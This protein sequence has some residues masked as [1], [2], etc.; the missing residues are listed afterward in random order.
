M[1]TIKTTPV[2]KQ[3]PNIT[4]EQQQKLKELF[5]QAF[6]EGKVDFD[7]LREALGDIVDDKPERYLFSWAGRRDSIRAYQSPSVATLAP[8]REESIDFDDTQNVFI[9]GENLEVLK[10]LLRPYFGQVKMIYIDPPY[11]EDG[12]YVY[13]DNY[14]D[15]LGEYERITGQRDSEGNLL[16]SSRDTSGRYH[17]NW[18][19]MIYPR[20]AL[21]RQLLKE[22]GAIFVSINDIEALSLRLVMNQL[23][24]EENFV[25]QMVWSGGRKNDSKLISVSHEY[26]LCYVKNKE[27]FKE[28]NI[29]WRQ[30]KPG[31]ED[32]YKTY[33]KF[34]KKHPGDHAK[35]EEGLKNWFRGLRNYHPAKRH[36]HYSSVDERG[37]YFP[38]DI[39]WPGGGGPQYEV[40]HPVTGKPCTVPA[41]GWMFSDPAKMQKA[42]SENKVHFGIDEQ[43]V[44]CIKA[45]LEERED[46][47]PYSVFYQDGRASTKRLRRLMGGD[48][49]E[50]PK[51]ELILKNLVEFASSAGDLIVDF[52]A[53]SCT[54]AHSVFLQ[55]QEDGEPRRFIMVQLPEPTKEDSNAFKAGYKNIAEIGKERIRR[56]GKK[57]KDGAAEGEDLGFRVFRLARSNYKQWDGAAEQDPEA[58][59]AQMG[60]FNDPLIEGWKVEDVI[61]E[62]ALKEGFKLTCKVEKLDSEENTI[63]RVSEG[64]DS[65]FI[66]LDD[67]VGSGLVEQLGL[68]KD[69]VF[70]CRDVALSDEQAANLALQCKLKTI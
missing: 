56:A 39:S 65:F 37:I 64:E 70:V 16:T 68:N 36:K 32:I 4:E 6:T 5:P 35:I 7:K 66:C 33:R 12:D 19:S 28:R 10:L 52:F 67:S 29:L 41:R 43:A 62:V 24:G 27:L 40:L 42:I 38:A 11:N 21:A 61:F 18:M 45:Y 51:D 13:E 25:A 53:G 58:Y 22:D 46:E 49:I 47:V 23:F 48:F 57:L 63:Y 31:L 14:R 30:R 34:K 55:N 60:M 3:T 20:L 8:V 2:E 59:L 54:T 1:S 9:E 44:P 17:S 50:H 15:P 69:T 26:V